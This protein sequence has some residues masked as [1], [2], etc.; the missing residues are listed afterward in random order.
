VIGYVGT[1][2]NAPERA[3]HLHFEMRELGEDKRWWRGTP[4]NP[5]RLLLAA[6]D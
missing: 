6:E 2:G 1:T 4:I 5:Y 3:P